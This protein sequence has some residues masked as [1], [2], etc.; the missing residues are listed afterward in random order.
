MHGKM[1]SLG[2]LNDSLARHLNDLGPVSR[3]QNVS[4]LSPS[5]VPLRA[6]HQSAAAVADDLLA[7]NMCC[8]FGMAGDI[9]S[10][11]LLASMTTAS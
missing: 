3:A 5:L 11:H 7:G 9:P 10:P 4:W 1:E 2:S 8:F 6:H